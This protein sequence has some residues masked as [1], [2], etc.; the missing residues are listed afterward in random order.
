[1]VLEYLRVLAWPAVV[2]GA[3]WMLAPQIKS[4]I[5]RLSEAS[6]GGATAKFTA[7]AR[8]AQE[9]STAVK[10]AAAAE[11]ALSDQGTTASEQ[12]ETA[13]DPRERTSDNTFQGLSRAHGLRMASALQQ[14]RYGPDFDTPREFIETSPPAAVMLAF[15][16]LEIL[17][18]E[19]LTAVSLG[20]VPTATGTRLVKDAVPNTPEARTLLGNLIAL[21]NNVV[22]AP[23]NSALTQGVGDYVDACENLSEA[24]YDI[25]MSKLRHPTRAI[26][27]AQLAEEMEVAPQ[28]LV[29]GIRT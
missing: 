29:P 14:L 17:S 28:E 1:M 16:E 27:I 23:P 11:E 3:L 19:A 4:A 2:S 13:R 5:G 6:W 20:V 10:T 26:T 7:V 21:R 15:R 9:Q 18:R 8:E 25:A 24:I 12:Q 22:H